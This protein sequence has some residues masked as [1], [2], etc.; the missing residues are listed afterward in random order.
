M[1]VNNLFMVKR[2]YDQLKNPNGGGKIQLDYS[3]RR[4]V[5]PFDVFW[6]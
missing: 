4:S 2:S 3:F 5:V 1:G 6:E